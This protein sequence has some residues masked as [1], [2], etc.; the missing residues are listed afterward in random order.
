MNRLL[1]SIP[2]W[3]YPTARVFCWLLYIAAF[4]VGFFSAW[5]SA[6]ALFAL[7]TVL[8]AFGYRGVE[9]ELCGSGVDQLPSA[10]IIRQ[11][12]ATPYIF[13]PK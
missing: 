7:G 6:L 13:W 4:G 12:Q 5:K 8:Y 3:A 10:D 9:V 2:S 1:K 11:Q